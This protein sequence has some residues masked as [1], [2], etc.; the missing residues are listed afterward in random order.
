MY[1]RQTD[2]Q[3]PQ[4]LGMAI[5]GK[6]KGTVLEEIPL[7]WTHWS[8]W[9]QRHSNTVVLSTDT[10]YFRSYG[11]DPYGSYGKSG[12]YYD[13]GGP[14]FPVMSTNDRFRPKDV[15]VG[16][17]SNGRQ[18]AIHKQTL[19]AKKVINTKL[20]G[21]PLAAIYDSDLDLARLFV[22]QVKERSTSFSFDNG[23][24]ADE[25][26]GSFWT[27]SGRSI[28][29]KMSGSQLQQHPSYDVMWFAWY[30]FFP[31]TQAV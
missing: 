29:G 13:S 14:L 30:A 26:T 25:L 27:A 9:R 2:S 15:V 5:D 11:T 12:T 17:K 21:L 28:D 7:A 3:W 23:R 1:D 24:I 6:N 20:A 8:R 16:A 18:M 19:R 22:R 31:E 4:I 10:G